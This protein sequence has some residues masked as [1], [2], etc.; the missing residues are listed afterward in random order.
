MV[1]KEDLIKKVA[2]NLGKDEETVRDVIM[3]H[4]NYV[5]YLAT[6]DEDTYS[7]YF[8]KLGTMSLNYYISRSEYK[9]NLNDRQRLIKEKAKGMKGLLSYDNFN[10][11]TP[12][13]LGDYLRDNEKFLKNP[14]K[15]IKPLYDEYSEKY[16]ELAREY[17]QI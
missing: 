7:L 16:N 5:E 13:V 12:H 10:Y 17:F 2:E 15:K 9:R 8:P 1:F 6:E 3:H 11:I 4:L 14:L